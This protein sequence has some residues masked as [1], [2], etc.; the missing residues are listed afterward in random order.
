MI[1]TFTY[2]FL[3]FNLVVCSGLLGFA[4]LDRF[5]CSD[6]FPSVWTDFHLFGPISICSD[7]FPFV[8]IDFHSFGSISICLD[9]FQSVRIDFICFDRFAFVRFDFHMFGSISICLDR[10][11]FVR[12]DF[13]IM[14]G[15]ISII[16]YV[17]LYHR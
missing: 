9:R 13:H 17:R 7:R 4:Y 16:L 6:R 12:T 14:F 11:L 15:L 2:P 5:I 1:R 3:C 10:F 8:R